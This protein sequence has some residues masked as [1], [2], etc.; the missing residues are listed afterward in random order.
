VPT[1]CTCSSWHAS[2]RGL[3]ALSV[4]CAGAAHCPSPGAA[5][6]HA[7]VR[8]Q[9][10]ARRCNRMQHAATP[11]PELLQ[12]MLAYDSLRLALGYAFV[13]Y[14]RYGRT[15]D[16]TAGAARTSRRNTA[17]MRCKS[18]GVAAHQSTAQHTA[19]RRSVITFVR[20]VVAVQDATC[21][22]RVATCRACAVQH[23]ARV[24]TQD[25]PLQLTAGAS[26]RASSAGYPRAPL[27]ALRCR[28]CCA[29][30]RRMR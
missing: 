4:R 17:R 18:G 28:A 11:L 2:S 12:R 6:S 22:A 8:S 20:R 14:P 27:P 23:A 3:A 26:E 25:G 7:C 16:S 21:R 29:S 9:H 15:V 10:V 30:P 5:R 13:R 1:R 24:A 19:R